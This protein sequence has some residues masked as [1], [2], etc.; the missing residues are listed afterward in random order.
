M[1]SKTGQSI[2]HH[3]KN[4]DT[5]LRADDRPDGMG[6]KPTEIDFRKLEQFMWTNP[7]LEHTAMFF[8][9]EQT[10]IERAIRQRHALTFADFREKNLAHTRKALI[11]KAISMALEKDNIAAL[12]FS[13]KNL[14]GWSD[15]IQVAVSP[16]QQIQLRYNLDKPADHP[17]N[18]AVEVV[19]VTP[20]KP[21]KKAKKVTKKVAKKKATKK[22][23]K[24]AKGK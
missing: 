23:T 8:E 10:T 15:N 5:R 3:E 13:L 19:D 24:K 18:H 22:I 14:A 21:K 17:K 16:H 7:T 11:Q 6:R 9:C 12:I 1:S 20:A 2:V 4:A